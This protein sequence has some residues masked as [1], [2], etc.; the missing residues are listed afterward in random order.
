[1]LTQLLVGLP[2]TLLRPYPLITFMYL[3]KLKKE[4]LLTRRQLLEG[5]L[6]EVKNDVGVALASAYY[7]LSIALLF[8]VIAPI[9]LGV[10][11]VFF[12]GLYVTM[13]Y[14]Y[15]Y[16][17]SRDCDSGGGFWKSIY[18]KSMTSLFI[19]TV[20]FIFYVAIKQGQVTAPF[21]FP[22]PFVIIYAWRYT[23]AKFKNEATEVAYSQILEI[24]TNSN[25]FG[26]F[27]SNFLKPPNFVAG[28]SVPQP[29][30]I[31]GVSLLQKPGVLS[32][33]YW[34]LESATCRTENL[35]PM[36][37][38]LDAEA[39]SNSSDKSNYVLFHD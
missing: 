12:I 32:P 20:L 33:I 11:A 2:L 8:W 15:L 6:L 30:R 3:W 17:F 4:K 28:E 19:S 24:D 5:P 18:E 36:T 21:L 1:M 13:K 10:S 29:Y 26:D 31:E 7:V 35:N 39:S 34:Q 14:Q 38:R 25:S 37:H 23:E 9:L 27:N 16:V 22:L